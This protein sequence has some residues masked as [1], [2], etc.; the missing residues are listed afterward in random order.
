MEFDKLNIDNTPCFVCYQTVVAQHQGPFLLTLLPFFP[1][2]D[3]LKVHKKLVMDTA[4]IADQPWPKHYSITYDVLS[5]TNLW[6]GGGR[7]TTKIMIFD[8]LSDYYSYFPG[9]G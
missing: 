5:N 3:L 6:K 9:S 8:F 7:A 1:L 4:G 2:S